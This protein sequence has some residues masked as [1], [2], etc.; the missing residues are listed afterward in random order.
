MYILINYEKVF[1]YLDK[2]KAKN[3]RYLSENEIMALLQLM[4]DLGIQYSMVSLYNWDLDLYI[5]KFYNK[6]SSTRGLQLVY[7]LDSLMTID[8]T[9]R[10]KP[11]ELN[12][13]ISTNFRNYVP[14]ELN[15]LGLVN[16]EQLI[17]IKEDI[18]LIHPRD[19]TELLQIMTDDLKI[20]E[21]VDGIKN[22]KEKQ[23][24]EPGRKKNKELLS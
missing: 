1:R 14:N 21:K 10:Y 13:I 15:K 2:K 23:D 18:N 4:F 19:L 12:K 5:K 16:D 3:S 22:I 8:A 9:K 6:F 20:L 11:K 17:S 24:S 7:F